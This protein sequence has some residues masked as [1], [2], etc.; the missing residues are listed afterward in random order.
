VFVMRPM[1]LLFALMSLTFQI[2]CVQMVGSLILARGTEEV[3]SE[4][5]NL[6]YLYPPKD[7]DCDIRVLSSKKLEKPHIVIGKVDT[8]I[9]RN[10]AMTFDETLKEDLE[11]E[12]RKQG[13]SLG[14]D[15]V[16][17]DELADKNSDTSGY[18]RARS[19][20]IKFK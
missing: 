20:V 2:G 4:V 3:S 10:M 17:I 16:I 15:M 11:K 6:G 19:S 1:L 13:C 12:L 7:A 8:H 5:Q 14:G 18:L 9:R